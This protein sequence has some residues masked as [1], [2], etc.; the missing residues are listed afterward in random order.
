MTPFSSKQTS[1]IMPHSTT[2]EPGVYW[3]F[4]IGQNLNHSPGYHVEASYIHQPQ[5]K[6]NSNGKNLMQLHIHFT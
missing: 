6:A 2:I 5:T 3:Y 1:A 4:V